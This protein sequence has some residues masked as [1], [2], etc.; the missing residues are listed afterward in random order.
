MPYPLSL[1]GMYLLRSDFGIHLFEAL[2]FS[3]HS[4]HFVSW[5]RERVT[6]IE[7]PTL[8]RVMIFEENH[9]WKARQGTPR[10]TFELDYLRM[11]RWLAKYC[12]VKVD[13]NHD[14]SQLLNAPLQPL[15]KVEFVDGVKKTLFR[16]GEH[17]LQLEGR[18]F[19]SLELEGGLKKLDAFLGRQP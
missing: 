18:V 7:L 16:V 2:G 5:C 14:S 8:P 13:K 17:Y 10:E 15:L 1:Y 12:Q 6:R 9:Q 4:K 3:P 11:E 19:S